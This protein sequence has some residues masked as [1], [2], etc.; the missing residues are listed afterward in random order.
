MYA[1]LF[2]YHKFTASEHEL[3]KEEISRL[4]TQVIQLKNLPKKRSI[5][6]QMS[7]TPI[8]S[9]APS[10]PPESPCNSFPSSDLFDSLNKADQE[11]GQINGSTA[12]EDWVTVTKK[13][14]NRRS[15]G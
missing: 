11:D 9:I 15:K 14:S 7:E 1:K 2:K 5:I 13:S 12:T 3:M 6:A 8:S 4:Q 10:T